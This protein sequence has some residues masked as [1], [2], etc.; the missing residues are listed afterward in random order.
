LFIIK[1]GRLEAGDNEE[2]K[3]K[4]NRTFSLHGGVEKERERM[5][6][7]LF[8]PYSG[9]IRLCYNLIRGTASFL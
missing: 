7:C 8:K 2:A 9:F 1:N 3:R 4:I 6:M 5:N